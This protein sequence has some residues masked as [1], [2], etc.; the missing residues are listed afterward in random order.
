[1]DEPANHIQTYF[2][3]V[4][5]SSAVNFP[6][7]YWQEETFYQSALTQNILFGLFYGALLI[8]VIYHLLLF[9]IS[10]EISYLYYV[11]FFAAWGLGQLGINGLAFQYL[12]ADAVW[13]GN[14]STPFFLLV[15][16]YMFNLWGRKSLLTQENTPHVDLFYKKLQ[17]I[18]ALSIVLSLFLTYDIVIKITLVFSV[19]LALSWTATSIYITK[20]TTKKGQYSVIYFILALL[21]YF[22]GVILFALKS[23][24]ILPG[25]FI[26]NWSLQIGGFFSLIFFSLVT[27]ER[28]LNLMFP[29]Y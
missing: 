20:I 14:I 23:L 7:T 9:F 4:Q 21:T 19:F 24:S 28:F 18:Y 15:A 6:L 16:M 29:R 22:I 11:L 26:T 1:M 12:W 13:W 17:F 25:N 5:T 3:R 2:L 8:M 27:T 10:K